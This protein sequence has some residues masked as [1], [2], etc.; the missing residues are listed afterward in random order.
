[1]GSG[2]KKKWREF[3]HGHP[4]RRF[5]ER[6][7][8]HRRAR[9]NKPWYSNFLKIALAIALILIGVVLLFMPGPAILFFAV[10]AALLA[11]HSQAVARP[12]DWT[13]V[14]VRQVLAAAKRWWR[15]HLCRRV[16]E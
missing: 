12:L 1:M 9:Q 11:D 16:A 14:K 13:E 4:G 10:G 3:Q 5:Q 6:Y 15:R 7:E 8:R 2:I